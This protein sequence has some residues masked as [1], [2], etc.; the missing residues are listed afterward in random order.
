MGSELTTQTRPGLKLS[1]YISGYAI[2]T[3]KIIEATIFRNGKV[4]KTLTPNT[5][6]WEFD[7]DDTDLI[8]KIVLPSKEEKPPF[9]FYYLRVIQED[10]HVAWGSP[11]WIDLE[12]KKQKKI[13]INTKK[14]K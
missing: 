13:A 9:I 14:K 6:E 3:S 1:R 5:Q 11:I 7:F 8:E 12:P 2:G 10:G 4:M